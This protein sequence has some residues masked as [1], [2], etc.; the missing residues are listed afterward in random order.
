MFLLSRATQYSTPPP[1]ET[2]II[3]LKNGG[4]NLIT[5]RETTSVLRRLTDDM[6]FDVNRSFFLILRDSPNPLSVCTFEGLVWGWFPPSS[7]EH[8]ATSWISMP[9]VLYISRVFFS[10][11]SF[12]FTLTNQ[13]IIWHENSHQEKFKSA[14]LA[15]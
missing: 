9:N 3:F 4:A 5:S 15:V 7:R 10:F 12:V 1:G 11:L 2:K 13:L 8:E 6:S 14:S